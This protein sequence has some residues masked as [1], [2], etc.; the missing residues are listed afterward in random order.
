[1]STQPNFGGG[2]QRDGLVMGADRR[3]S[4][5][6]GSAVHGSPIADLQVSDGRTLL[7]RVQVVTE[8]RIPVAVGLYV[9]IPERA[10]HD[11]VTRFVAALDLPRTHELIRALRVAV[12]RLEEG[13]LPRPGLP[14]ASWRAQG[15]HAG[16]GAPARSCPA[17]APAGED[18][19]HHGQ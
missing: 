13:V 18:G 8:Q 9:G 7:V 16:D 10:G 1:M 12:A 5:S 19:G 6:G 14:P 17:R 15:D 11:D 4:R 3:S 2:A